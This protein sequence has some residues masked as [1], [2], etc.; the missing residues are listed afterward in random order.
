MR[1]TSLGFIYR[2]LRCIQPGGHGIPV[3]DKDCLVIIISACGLAG[4]LNI[5]QW[6]SCTHS[7]LKPATAGFGWEELFLR[8]VTEPPLTSSFTEHR[9]NPFSRWGGLGSRA[10]LPASKG[11]HP[12]EQDTR[13]VFTGKRSFYVYI[14]MFAVKDCLLQ[15]PCGLTELV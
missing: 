13:E 7:F 6:S 9:E 15:P 2:P 3:R 12:H 11:N 8:A 14:Y 5:I 10:K 1:R 4:T